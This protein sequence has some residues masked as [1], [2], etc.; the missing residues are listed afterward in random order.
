MRTYTLCYNPYAPRRELIQCFEDQE[1]K[2]TK[3]FLTAVANL[4][5]KNDFQDIK[6]LTKKDHEDI[7]SEMIL[8]LLCEN[9]SYIPYKI[10]QPRKVLIKN[11]TDDS[12]TFGIVITF[13][14]DGS[15]NDIVE[16]SIFHTTRDRPKFTDERYF[17][18]E[19]VS[20]LE[21]KWSE[22]VLEHA[23]S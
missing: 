1:K 13:G 4:W 17:Y 5:M 11:E 23:N 9:G 3:R 10:L 7:L 20:A 14:V 18:S 16:T 21:E 15:G 8:T 2:Y 22:K 19:D 12:N 6:N